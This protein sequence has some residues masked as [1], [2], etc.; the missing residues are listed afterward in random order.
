[1]WNMSIWVGVDYTGLRGR[2]EPKPVP[3]PHSCSVPKILFFM[4]QTLIIWRDVAR[5]D[6]ALGETRRVDCE[7]AESGREDSK[8]EKSRTGDLRGDG[9]V[10]SAEAGGNFST[11]AALGE[12]SN[13]FGHRQRW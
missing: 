3:I 4:F 6:F 11:A 5:V 7:Q 9:P 13:S 8:A 2:F 1:M 12:L 10:K